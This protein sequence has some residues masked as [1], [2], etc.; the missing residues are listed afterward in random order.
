MEREHLEI[1]LSHYNDL[2]TMI[3]EQ[4]ELLLADRLNEFIAFSSKIQKLQEKISRLSKKVV[5]NSPMGDTEM[6]YR[7][8]M[9]MIQRI[10]SSIQLMYSRMEKE[11]TKRKD[12][13]KDEAL[14][15]KKGQYALKGYVRRDKTRPRFVEKVT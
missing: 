13:L 2:Q 15:I 5:P 9:D 1:L 3:G 12:F 7:E 11:I 4:L 6:G 14:R 8:A 10:Q